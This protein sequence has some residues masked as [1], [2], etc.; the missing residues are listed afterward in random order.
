M[1]WK[2]INAHL[3]DLCSARRVT[4]DLNLAGSLATKSVSAESDVTS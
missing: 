1:S 2:R 4:R 3:V